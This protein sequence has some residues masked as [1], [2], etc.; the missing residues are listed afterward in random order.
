MKTITIAGLSALLALYIGLGAGFKIGIHH[1]AS[2]HREYIRSL[3]LG[4][5]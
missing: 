4:G 1:E 5:K 3:N 2:N